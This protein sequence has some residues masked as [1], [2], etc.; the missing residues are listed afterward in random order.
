MIYEYTC[1]TINCEQ[2]NKE[3]LINKPIAESG[4]EE[5]CPAC[6][7]VMQRMYDMVGHSTFSDGYK[8]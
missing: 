2:R 8:S 7:S 4:R 1:N 6:G 5:K 3:V